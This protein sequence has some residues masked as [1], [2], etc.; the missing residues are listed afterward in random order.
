M[1]SISVFKEMK[2]LYDLKVTPFAFYKQHKHVWKNVHIALF[3]H[4][5]IHSNHAFAQ[6]NVQKKLAHFL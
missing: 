1:I 5:F 2:G 4:S 6:Q 3:I